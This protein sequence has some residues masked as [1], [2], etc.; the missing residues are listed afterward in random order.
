[1]I[2]KDTKYW[3]NLL[4]PMSPNE[5]EVEIYKHHIKGYKPV[6]LLGMTEKLQPICDFMVDLYP[7]E[8]N[9]LVIEQ[10]WN[11][12]KEP[13]EAVIGDGVI[14]LE[15]LQ[16]VEKLIK[17]YQRLVFRV[18]LKKF[19]WIKYAQHFPTEFP[20]SKLIIPTQ[21]NIAIVVY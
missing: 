20:G 6:C 17:N 1:M 8:Q 19:E 4:P 3:Q 5:Y 2:K 21:E 18:F 10:N 14:N 16:L 7:I 13:A 11:D 9:K 15:G 12:L